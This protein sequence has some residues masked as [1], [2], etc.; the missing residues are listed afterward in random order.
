MEWSLVS[1]RGEFQWEAKDDDADVS[2]QRSVDMATFEAFYHL[3]S[4]E[5]S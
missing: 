3:Y 2:P 5:P 4:L 1:L